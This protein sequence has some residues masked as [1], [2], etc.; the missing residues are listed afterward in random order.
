V[1]RGRYAVLEPSGFAPS[2]LPG[3]DNAVCHVVISPLLGA[4]FC[5]LLITL[6]REGNGRGNTGRTEF[7]VFMV[8]GTGHITVD[9]KKHRLDTGH[10]GYFPPGKDLYFQ[11]AGSG[12]KILIFQKEYHPLPGV[13]PPPMLFAHERDVKSHPLPGEENAKLQILLEDTPAHDLAVNVLT[14]QPGASLPFLETH[15]M[16]HGFLVLKGQGICRLDGDYHP[17]RAGDVIWTAPFCP[18]WF[19]AMGNSPASY[20]YFK[21]INR[22]PI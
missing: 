16:E 2:R 4:R 21:D 6:G 1:V 9:D 19:V 7:F 10:F 3:W 17:V 5:Q 22:D 15:V 11:G 18:R 20:I 12:A 14:C 8:E 13:P